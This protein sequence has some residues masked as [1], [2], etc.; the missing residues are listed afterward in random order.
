MTATI[1][2]CMTRDAP[3]KTAES[4]DHMH[5][6]DSSMAMDMCGLAEPVIPPGSFFIAADVK[7]M[8]G[9]IAHHGQAIV[10]AAMAK[11]HG[12][13]PQ[14]L[15]FTLKIAQS[16]TA[17]I[18]LMQN[19][20]YDREQEVPDT[21]AYHHMQM[22]GMLTEQQM[23]DLDAAKGKAFDKLFLEYM[24]QHHEGALKMVAELQK[25]QFSMQD[26]MLSGFAADVDTDQRAEILKMHTML[27][28][29]N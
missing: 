26:I 18:G 4:M 29:M 11:S 24:I 10:M 1:A 13:N 7:F 21:S 23:K 20:L 27:D 25:T 19:W 22:P 14:M 9:M 28:E 12:A 8:Q 6:A 17:E 3:P 5:M 15:K 2:A 16:Q